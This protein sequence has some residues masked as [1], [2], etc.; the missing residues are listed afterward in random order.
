MEN[1]IEIIKT[2]EQI[3]CYIIRNRLQPDKTVFITPPE[4]KQQVGFVVYKKGGVI[5][6]H[7]HRSLERHLIG[8]SEVLVVRS[9]RCAIDVYDDQK[10]L[11]TT[12]DLTEGDVVIMSAGGHGFRILEDTILLE[13]KQGPYL[14]TE[15]KELF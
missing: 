2:G 9:G 11:V 1:V 5:K 3:L 4:S 12:R 10:N 8:M 13:I 6:R 15:D 7:I 14:G